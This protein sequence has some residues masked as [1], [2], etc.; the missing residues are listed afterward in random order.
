MLS[1]ALWI[2][3]CNWNRSL[4]E[5]LLLSLP[6]SGVSQTRGIRDKLGDVISPSLAATLNATLRQCGGTKITLIPVFCSL[7]PSVLTKSQSYGDQDWSAWR[8]E[9]GTGHRC[10]PF[11]ATKSPSKKTQEGQAQ[12]YIVNL[13]MLKLFHCCCDGTFQP[14]CFPCNVRDVVESSAVV[15]VVVVFLMLFIF[16]LFFVIIRCIFFKNKR[17]KCIK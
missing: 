17:I 6:L 15:N 16:Y 12:L 9:V 13:F 14:F 4:T 3:L 1:T 8:K 7:M 2:S 10:P 11:F 5:E